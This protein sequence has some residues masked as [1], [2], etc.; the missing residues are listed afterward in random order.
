MPE[1]DCR[2]S[3][4]KYIAAK[5]LRALSGLFSPKLIHQSSCRIL[6]THVKTRPILHDDWSIRM[7]ENRLYRSSQTFG[8]YAALKKVGVEIYTSD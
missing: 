7:G 6:N 2:H 1:N 8:S 5:W 3:A 4:L